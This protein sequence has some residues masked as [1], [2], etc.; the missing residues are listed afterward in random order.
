MPGSFTD[1]P[2]SGPVGMILTKKGFGHSG[3]YLAL[4]KEAILRAM[5]HRTDFFYSYAEIFY[6]GKR[7]FRGVRAHSI[8]RLQ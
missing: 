2:S 7:H 1:L 3:N 5:S 6:G 8:P 4:N